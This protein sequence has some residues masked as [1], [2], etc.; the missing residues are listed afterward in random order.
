MT[1]RDLHLMFL[2]DTGLRAEKYVQ[3]YLKWLENEVFQ[4]YQW[5][6]DPFVN[7]ELS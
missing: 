7:I 1:E 6:Y 2:K 5:W 3:E 4:V